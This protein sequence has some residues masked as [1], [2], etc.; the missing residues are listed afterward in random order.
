MTE[1]L[2]IQDGEIKR[3]YTK[4]EYAQH[5]ADKAEALALA[6]QAAIKAEAKAT[7]LQKLGITED[8]AKLL[9]S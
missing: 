6:E 9:L 7:L 3:E 4:A 1:K 8:E 5:E 2:F